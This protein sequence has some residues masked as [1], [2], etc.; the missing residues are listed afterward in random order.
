[1]IEGIRV[2]SSKVAKVRQMGRIRETL[3]E[4]SRESGTGLPA[5]ECSDNLLTVEAPIFNED[6]ARMVSSDDDS[7]QEYTWNIA[8]M[9]LRI[10]RW[11]IGGRIE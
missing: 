5:R 4:R 1:M 10:H 9:G 8:F 11:L 2:Q 7:R 6:F 3:D